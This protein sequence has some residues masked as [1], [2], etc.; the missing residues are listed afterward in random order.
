MTTPELSTEPTGPPHPSLTVAFTFKVRFCLISGCFGFSDILE[1]LLVKA[2][3]FC[4]QAICDTLTKLPDDDLKAVKTLLWKRYPRS[5]TTP[6][7][8][9]DTL[10]LVDRLLVCFQ[11]EG[12]LQTTE[13]LL[14]EIGQ[15]KAAAY[16]QTLRIR[17]ENIYEM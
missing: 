9:M 10:D 12:S 17:S 6:P 1:V 5:F 11:L 16:L 7:Q 13:T 14:A 8:H 2:V 3:F 15:K 4:N